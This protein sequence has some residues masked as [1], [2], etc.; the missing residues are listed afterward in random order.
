VLLDPLRDQVARHA[1]PPAAG[2][3]EIVPGVL[4]RRAEVLGAAALVLR[5]V[6]GFALAPAGDTGNRKIV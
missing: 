1:V 5:D 6:E 2:R 3:V 4:G